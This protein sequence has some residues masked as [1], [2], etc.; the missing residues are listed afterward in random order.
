[1]KIEE[2]VDPRMIFGFLVLLLLA[3]LAGIIAIGKVEQETSYGLEYI[4]GA[5]SVLAGG[6]A[7]WAFKTRPGD[8][9]PTDVNATVKSDEKQP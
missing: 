4:L 3:I 1:M 9:P 5:L 8:V 7:Q 6:F 2:P